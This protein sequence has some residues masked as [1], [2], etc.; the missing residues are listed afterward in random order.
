MRTFVYELINVLIQE[1]QASETYGSVLP[2]PWSLYSE[3]G[4]ASLVYDLLF[5]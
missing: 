2:F 3:H 1:A 5:L 4:Q